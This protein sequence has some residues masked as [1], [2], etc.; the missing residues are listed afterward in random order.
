M[1]STYQN[2]QKILK[3]YQ[4][5]IFFKLN[6]LLKYTQIQFWIKKQT[7]PTQMN[8]TKKK[9]QEYTRVIRP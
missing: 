9:N 3:K 2:Y 8:N 6:A 5:D 7:M 1:I 4:F